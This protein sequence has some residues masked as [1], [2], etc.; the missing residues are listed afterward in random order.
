M[1]KKAL[2]TGSTDGIGRATAN[3]LALHGFDVIIHGRSQQRIDDTVN[4]IKNS[5][6]ETTC[7]GIKADL[8]S[9]KE[10][11]SMAEEIIRKKL[12]PDVLI[13]NAGVDTKS[14]ALTPDGYEMTFAVNHLSH[15]YLTLLL[16]GHLPENARIINVSSRLHSSASN[17][18]FNKIHSQS[19]YN[20]LDAYCISKLCNVLFTYK[21]HRL[22]NGKRNI[23]VNCLHPGVINTKM[24]IQGW[25][26]IGALV[27]EGAKTPVYL[28]ASQDV[29]NISGAYFSDR[30][31]QP[32][33]ALS[34]DLKLQ[35]ECWN[36]SLEMIRKA[37]FDIPDFHSL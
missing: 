2:V 9:L 7:T 32:S 30:K 29:K 4:Q 27:E 37:G 18:N 19:Y 33:S 16:T 31:R 35:D 17:I 28:A 26:P 13:N 20:S 22:L 3:E 14:F 5:Y 21:L 15:F 1:N 24:L 34:H 25:G 6:P 8:S 23:T 10:V 36:K 11:R 12:V